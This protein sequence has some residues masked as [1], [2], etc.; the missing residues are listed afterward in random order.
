M[1]HTEPVDGAVRDGSRYASSGCLVCGDPW[2]MPAPGSVRRPIDNSPIGFVD[3]RR[4][5]RMSRTSVAN[6]SGNDGC[7]HHQRVSTMRGAL[8][9]RAPLSVLSLVW[10]IAGPGWSL[11]GM[12]RPNPAVR[13]ARVGRSLTPE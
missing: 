5:P 9:R 1:K 7:A 3:A 2:W 12:R 11:S 13:S 8:R 6:C 4:R 10:S